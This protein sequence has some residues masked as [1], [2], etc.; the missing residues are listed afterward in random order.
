M[1]F[2]S[3]FVFS[4]SVNS[5]Y[6]VN[7]VYSFK[8]VFIVI[9]SLSFLLQ[10]PFSASCVCSKRDTWKHGSV[11]DD[12]RV[13]SVEELRFCEVDVSK[14]KDRKCKI[15]QACHGRIASEL[16]YIRLGVIL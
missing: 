14:N 16:K 9:L 10:M 3:V 1:R 13:A 12:L 6:N 11:S 2:S 8:S 15:C 4:E 5:V 7:S